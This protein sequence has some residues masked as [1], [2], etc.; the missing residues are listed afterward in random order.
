VRARREAHENLCVVWASNAG[1]RA[2]MSQIHKESSLL[3]ALTVIPPL[4]RYIII[5]VPHTISI[6][7]LLHQPLSHSSNTPPHQHSSKMSSPPS[8]PPGSSVNGDMQPVA[9]RA[10]GNPTLLDEDHSIAPPNSDATITQVPNISQV[11]NNPKI[12]AV[13]RHYQ[14]TLIHR[15]WEGSTRFT[16]IILSK[17]NSTTGSVMMVPSDNGYNSNA[18]TLFVDGEDGQQQQ[19]CSFGELGKLEF[20]R[21]TTADPKNPKGWLAHGPRMGPGNWKPKGVFVYGDPET[22]DNDDG[23]ISLMVHQ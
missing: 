7:H 21:L 12:S 1:Q 18:S 15:Y 4:H 20:G 6:Q 16:D 3:T 9:W 11:V 2:R 23:T 22:F 10:D 13:G 14:D 17:D 8:V 19:Q 5:T